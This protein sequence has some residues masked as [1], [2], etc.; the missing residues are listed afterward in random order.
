MQI[1]ATFQKMLAAPQRH[2]YMLP[3]EKLQAHSDRDA[4]ILRGKQPGALAN[5]LLY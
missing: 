5:Q 4:N 2:T 1:Y 3:T